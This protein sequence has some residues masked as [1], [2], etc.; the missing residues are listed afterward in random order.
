MA[1]IEN[2]D[3]NFG[4]NHRNCQKQAPEILHER[5]GRKLLRLWYSGQLLGI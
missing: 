3:E 1:E 5:W 4:E 2:V